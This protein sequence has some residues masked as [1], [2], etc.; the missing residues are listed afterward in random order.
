MG[1]AGTSGVR[2]GLTG[3]P[4]GDLLFAKEGKLF[5]IAMTSRA[6]LRREGFLLANWLILSPLTF[7]PREAPPEAKKW[8]GRAPAGVLVDTRD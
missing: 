1:R 4:S 7:V 3:L 5:R 2:T 6:S 8:I